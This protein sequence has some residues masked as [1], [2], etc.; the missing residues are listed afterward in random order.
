[1][2]VRTVTVSANA[3][4]TVAPD[5]ATVSFSE[6]TIGADPVKIEADNA[7]QMNAAIS[8][9]KQQG[10]DSNDIATTDYNLSPNYNYLPK[11]GKTSIV[12]YTITETETVKIRDF[13]KIPT[14]LAGLANLGV[15]QIGQV[16]FSIEDPDSHLATARNEAFTKAQLKAEQMAADNGVQLGE[17]VNFTESTNGVEPFPV[18]NEMSAPAATMGSAVAPTIESGTQQ[19]TDTVS[20]TYAIQ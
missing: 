19:L 11:T 10:V 15:N 5:L 2:P 6:V 9:V 8:F 16:S 17:I 14:L 13:T 7:T 20:I 4:T 1:M 3:Q 12:S 18:Y